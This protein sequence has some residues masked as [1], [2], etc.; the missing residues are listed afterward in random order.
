MDVEHKGVIEVE[1]REDFI[2]NNNSFLG[3]H[4]LLQWKRLPHFGNILRN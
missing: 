3:H 2:L 4:R 1:V